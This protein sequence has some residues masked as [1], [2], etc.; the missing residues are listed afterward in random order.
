M[1]TE[2]LALDWLDILFYF[3]CQIFFL[4]WGGFWVGW[5]DSALLEINRGSLPSFLVVS[6]EMEFLTDPLGFAKCWKQNFMF[7]LYLELLSVT[8]PIYFSCGF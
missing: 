5:L 8:R 3:I 7:N 2:T 4:I 1:W 6:G